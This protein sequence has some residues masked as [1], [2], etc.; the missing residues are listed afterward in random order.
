MGMLYN[1]LIVPK[2][3]HLLHFIAVTVELLHSDIVPLGISGRRAVPVLGARRIGGCSLWHWRL[4]QLV[5]ASAAIKR[6]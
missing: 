6:G 4:V 3:I 1:I 5:L 2:A